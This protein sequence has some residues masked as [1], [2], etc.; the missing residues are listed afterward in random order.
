MQIKET[1]TGNKHIASR[2]RFYE[3]ERIRNKYRNKHDGFF[4]NKVLEA[5]ETD[6]VTKEVGYKSL[7]FFSLKSSKLLRIY[8]H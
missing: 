6:V 1:G 5:I 7:V 3:E 4:K 8:V 2:Q